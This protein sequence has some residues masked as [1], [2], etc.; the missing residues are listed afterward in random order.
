M[1]RILVVGLQCYMLLGTTFDALVRIADMP[2][3]MYQPLPILR[4]LMAP[5]VGF[6]IV[7]PSES[8]L[9]LIFWITFLAGGAALFGALTNASLGVFAVGNV[10]LQAYLYS[11]R[12]YHHPEA[13]MIVG[14]CAL[15]LAP[16]GK[17]MSIDSWLRGRRYKNHG[18]AVPLLEYSGNDATWAIRFIQ[19][20]FSLMYISAAVSKLSWGGL[21]WAN[22]Y[23]LQYKLIQDGLRH[24]REIALWLAQFHVSIFLAQI[25]IMVFQATYFLVIF[26]PKLRW[27]YLPLGLSMHIG[28]YITL[29]AA[30]PQ[31]I[32]FYSV[33]IPWALAARKLA[34][35]TITPH[36]GS[37][38]TA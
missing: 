18:P 31:W 35:A 37:P 21:E 26:F 30:F 1:I 38:S 19:C 20:F 11:F 36:S 10:V 27:V 24:E 15:A 12:D 25:V 23:T 17:V 4:L 13:L 33:Y 2:P 32:I 34:N 22:G 28:I 8:V 3:E 6:D 7:R 29:N 16:S 5:F 9:M 14:L